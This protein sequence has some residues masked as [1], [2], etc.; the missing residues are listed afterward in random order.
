MTRASLVRRVY[1]ERRAFVLPLLVLLILNLVALVLGVLPI[2]RVVTTAR[3]DASSAIVEHAAAV[4]QQA[5]ARNLVDRRQQVDVELATFYRDVLPA[6]LNEARRLFQV[7]LY[8]IARDR[9]LQFTSSDSEFAELRDSRL[10]RVQSEVRLRGRY[11]DIRR[12]IRD[13]ETGD[14]FVIV[15]GVQLG[16]T[17]LQT[18]DA[19]LELLLSVA[20]YFVPRTAGGS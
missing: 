15:E 13:V 4:R 10:V 16:E 1:G 20:T 7:W 17:G 12:F 5:E 11:V 18:G 14:D 8:E 9:D 6:N 3:E 19:N 2:R